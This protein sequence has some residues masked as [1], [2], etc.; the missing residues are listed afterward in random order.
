M[1]WE[2]RKEGDED[3]SLSVWT[4]SELGGEI[5]RLGGPGG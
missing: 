4:G 1:G 3:L 2:E 5:P